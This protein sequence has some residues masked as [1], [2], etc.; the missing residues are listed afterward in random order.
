MDQ[1]SPRP[2]PHRPPQRPQ[3]SQPAHADR[4]SPNPSEAPSSPSPRPRSRTAS[5]ASSPHL[6]RKQEHTEQVPEQPSRS[7]SPANP[8]AGSSNQQGE[9]E[10]GK[11]VCQSCN[12]S[13]SFRDETTGKF[14]IKLWETHRQT[15]SASRPVTNS[16]N[17][18]P[19]SMTTANASDPVIYTPE[20]T[21]QALANPP[22][23]RRRAKRTE[24]E[25]IAY[26]RADP[27]VADFEPYRV[28]CASCDKWIR[29]RPNSTYCSIPWDAHRKSCLAKKINSKNVYALE[30]RNNVFAKDPEVRKFDAE[31]A[32]CNMCDRWIPLNPEDHLQ[33]VQKWLHHRASC[34]KVPSLSSAA[35][36]GPATSA[37]THPPVPSTAAAEGSR[38]PSTDQKQLHSVQPSV[39]HRLPPTSSPSGLPAPGTSPLFGP[40]S[41]F[42]SYSDPRSFAYP[43]SLRQQQHHLQHPTSSPGA[44]PFHDLNPVNYAPIHESRR[45]NA[46]QRAATLRADSL[47]GEVEPNRVFCSLCQK[48]VQLRQDSSYCAYPWLQHRGKCLARHQR[49]VQK[50]AEVVD[51]K[52]RGIKNEED[53]LMSD[54]NDIPAPQSSSSSSRY[55]HHY[56]HHHHQRSHSSTVKNEDDG[57]VS[58]EPE[59]E[60]EEDMDIRQ[61]ERDSRLA[62]ENRSRRRSGEG[63]VGST[64]TPS[65]ASR[66]RTADSRRHQDH[67]HHNGHLAHREYQYHNGHGHGHGHH[68]YQRVSKSHY[69]PH[70]QTQRLK[71]GLSGTS[72]VSNS[73]RS[74]V[75]SNGSYGHRINGTAHHDV[76]GAPQYNSV[77]PGASPPGVMSRV[78]A[79]NT[80]RPWTEDV[81]DD[82]D[83]DG[84]LDID[85]DGDSVMDDT[86]VG[87]GSSA[88]NSTSASAANGAYGYSRTAGGVLQGR[89]PWPPGLA[90]LDSPSGR[91]QFVHASVEYLFATTYES[92]DDMSISTLLTYLNAA[93]PVDKH[94]DF[95]TSEVTKAALAIQEKG[96][97]ILQ[98]DML[99]VRS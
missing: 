18:A 50:A 55:S 59:P 74:S 44:S 51:L 88:A 39:S 46:E 95:D 22:A 85:A 13:I 36:S 29:L 60:S 77:G 90:D 97:F 25:R 45:R 63:L 8:A 61:R 35:A 23:K 41:S 82:M 12:A 1:H 20:S 71:M 38:P 24:E 6:K 14:N 28:L 83:A 84:D 7:P 53:E 89:R 99:C 27:Y 78:S 81:D 40:S 5:P 73:G 67:H 17:T 57:M 93:M 58:D 75:H 37:N 66:S 76:R 87:G 64:M 92:S 72:N 15:C 65:A 91:R 52:K 86:V 69:Q 49:R 32:L 30:E 11:V 4:R 2:S 21:A 19:G 62:E 47:I 42:P 96:R 48:W 9:Y 10:S 33:A 70:S 31:R 26:L 68:P 43:G 54:A 80:S 3:P 79:G 56:H 16:N 94:E 34:Q 98:G